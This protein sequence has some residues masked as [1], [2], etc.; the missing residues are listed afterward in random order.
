MNTTPTRKVTAG[1]LGS[2]TALLLVWGLNAYAH[3]NIDGVGSAAI[4]GF[5]SALLAYLTKEPT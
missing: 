3:A 4:T 2:A 5:L 1:A